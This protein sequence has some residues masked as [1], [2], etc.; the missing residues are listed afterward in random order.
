MPVTPFHFGPGLLGKAVVNRV[1]IDVETAY[2]L[3]RNE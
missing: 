1:V 2:H 3:V